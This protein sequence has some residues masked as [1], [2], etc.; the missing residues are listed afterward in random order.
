MM[1]LPNST[2][3]A[4]HWVIADVAP[5]FALLDVWALPAQGCAQDFD[6]LIDIVESFDP[7]A[8]DSTPARLLF[9]LRFQIGRW[10]RWDEPGT[11]RAI[12]GATETALRQRLPAHLRGTPSK[13]TRNTDLHGFVPLYRTADE[14]AAE[15]S[16]ATVH[17]ALQL[18]W[19]QTGDESDHGQ[20]THAGR[21]AV[22]VKA[23]GRRGELY[24]RLIAPARHL[25]VYP[26]ILRQLGR[27]WQR[28]RLSGTCDR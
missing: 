27:A 19:V 8:A 23:R 25:V 2:H 1:R 26:A 17:G 18:T 24:L 3:E 4:H 6:R 11:P 28:D 14:W 20:D 13:R 16:N 21:L 22:Y 15:I 12:P 7:A 9:K 10:L 5:D